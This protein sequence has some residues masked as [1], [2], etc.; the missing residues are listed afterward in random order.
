MKRTTILHLILHEDAHSLEH[1]LVLLGS[2]MTKFRGESLEVLE[3]AIELFMASTSTILELCH[4]VQVVRVLTRAHAGLVGAVG[5]DLLPGWN[6]AHESVRGL[7]DPEIRLGSPVRTVNPYKFIVIDCNAKFISE[8][9]AIE[10]V[11]IPV[12]I[13][14]LALL[15]Q[16]A[17]DAISRHGEDFT[18]ARKIAPHNLEFN[19]S[20]LETE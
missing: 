18:I 13:W 19:N 17:V 16:L 12:G 6:L 20:M 8:A 3:P 11:R 4:L 2:T 7:E 5:N 1:G 9:W 15:E 14:I 10:L